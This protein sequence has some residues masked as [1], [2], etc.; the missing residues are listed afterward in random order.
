[1]GERRRRAALTLVVVDTSRTPIQDIAPHPAT[2]CV[3]GHQGRW[4]SSDVGSHGFYDVQFPLQ[5][6]LWADVRTGS[7][8]VDFGDHPAVDLQPATRRLDVP[9]HPSGS[10]GAAAVRFATRAVIPAG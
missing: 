5:Q 3:T 6:A 10:L 4:S 2:T 8:G 9:L 7:R 1:M